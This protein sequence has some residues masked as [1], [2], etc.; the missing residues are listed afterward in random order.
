MRSV[1]TIMTALVSP[2]EPGRRF[3][4]AANER[5][6][7][8]ICWSSRGARS[9]TGCSCRADAPRPTRDSSFRA[10]QLVRLATR[11]RLAAALRDSVR[12]VDETALTRRRRPQTLVDASSVRTCAAE[13]ADLARAVT[14][15]NPRVRGL[16]IV[17]DLPTDGL[18]PLYT[19]GQTERLRNTVRA[20]R[21]APQRRC[22]TIA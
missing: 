12:S 14:D 7:G 22:A 19:P 18:G 13:I 4:S 5:Q 16:A 21:S 1:K 20:A 10:A 17:S 8:C 2:L 11:A 9:S 6:H 15:V 3:A